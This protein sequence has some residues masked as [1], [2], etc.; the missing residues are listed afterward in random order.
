MEGARGVKHTP[1]YEQ[2]KLT[3]VY[4]LTFINSWV[5]V[6]IPVDSIDIINRVFF[7]DDK[8]NPILFY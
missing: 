6:Q 1:L 5:H 3:P 4:A 8:W 2:L 7:Y